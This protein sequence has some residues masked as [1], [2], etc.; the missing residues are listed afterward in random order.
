MEVHA[1][2]AFQESTKRR[3]DLLRAATVEQGSTQGQWGRQEMP[4]A[5][6]VQQAHIQEKSVQLQFLPAIRVRKIQFHQ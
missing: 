2:S 4:P 5:A 1:S 3:Q 6:T